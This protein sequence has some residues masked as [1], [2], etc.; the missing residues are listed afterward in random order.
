V[1]SSELFNCLVGGLTM[2]AAPI[3][4]V[5]EAED[6]S[7]VSSSVGAARRGHVLLVEDNAT[8]QL[9]ATRMLTKLGYEVDVA[10]N[11]LE[12]LNASGQTAYD[13]VL[14]DCQ[15]PEMDGYQATAAIRRREGDARHTPIIAMTAAAMEGDRDVCLA[16]GMDDYIAKPVRTELLLEVLGRWI[17]PSQ[18]QVPTATDNPANSNS[19]DDADEKAPAL[20]AERFETMRELD[21]GDGE[22]LRLVAHEFLADARRQLQALRDAVS[23]HDPFTVERTAHSLKGASAAIGALGLSDL[24]AQL[25]ILG[26]GGTVSSGSS[27]VGRID[28]ELDRVHDALAAAMT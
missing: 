23:E 8:N 17:R 15:M 28:D 9:V 27:L 16:A 10:N 11:G 18:Q 20:D 22:L 3:P 7:S 19:V 6:V 21:G 24:C 4:A 13:A 5:R 1:R 25:E 12:A 14:M 26:R 2:P